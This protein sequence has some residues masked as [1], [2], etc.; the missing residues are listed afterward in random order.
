MADASRELKL[1][2][3][4]DTGKSKTAL[5]QFKGGLKDLNV[6][7]LAVVATLGLVAK[8][9]QEAVKEWMDATLAVGDFADKTGTSVEEA[10]ALL[11]I[12]G[13][14]GVGAGT[15]EAAFKKMS[16][17]GFDP[18][19][20]GLIAVRAQ[21]DATSGPSERLELS[22]KLLGKSGA[23]LLPIFAQLSNTE[24]RK[25]AEGMAAGTVKTEDEVVQSRL[26]RDNLDQLGDTMRGLANQAIG[27]MVKALNEEI[28]SEKEANTWVELRTEASIRLRE[29]GIIPTI[30]AINQMVRDMQ[31]SSK[32]AEVETARYQGL[33]DQYAKTGDAVDDLA[34][35]VK[36]L[37]VREMLAKAYE[38]KMAGD[39]AMEKYWLK[40]AR[41]AQKATDAV[42]AYIAA[43][44]SAF[45]VTE[46]PG[47]GV[48]GHFES[49][50]APEG[51]GQIIHRETGDFKVNADGTWTRLAGGGSLTGFN[52][53]G[54]VPGMAGG[55]PGTEGIFQGTVIPHGPWET[56]KKWLRIIP[57]KHGTPS[58]D[59]GGGGG[60]VYE[61]EVSGYGDDAFGSTEGGQ[62]LPGLVENPDIPGY[63]PHYTGNKNKKTLSP[64]TGGGGAA[65][66]AQQASATA[67]AAMAAAIPAAV[68]KAAADQNREQLAETRRVNDNM[69]EE[70]KRMRKAV[71]KMNRNL[72]T[73][74][75]DS[76]SKVVS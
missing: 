12:A 7:G 54:D 56:I 35:D 32:V 67:A 76:V 61:P 37:S 49:R 6:G 10:S 18:S 47:R 46:T 75:R 66:A 68:A 69:V 73:W 28:A 40:Q 57:R 4:S 20:E 51:A 53:V 74:I 48:P 24:L 2:L 22:L 26:L 50:P 55:G 36:D 23:D 14:L 44:E 58:G 30:G 29:Q 52:E 42:N 9:T 63:T 39:E 72:P 71:E 34:T 62:G 16:K 27:P 31:I 25:Y 33:A 3:T 64:F 19:I 41:S 13:D 38:A 70:M 21:L 43:M 17:E 65:A 5:D 45:T 11:E 60:Y 8:K 15:L 59:V 1:R